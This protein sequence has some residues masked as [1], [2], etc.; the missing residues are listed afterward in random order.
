MIPADVA[1]AESPTPLNG[2]PA[3]VTFRFNTTIAAIAATTQSVHTGMRFQRSTITNDATSR[4]SSLPMSFARREAQAGPAH[5]TTQN[6]ASRFRP[7]TR[8]RPKR[9]AA[10]S[11]LPERLAT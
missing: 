9:D 7:T 10:Y 11:R 8:V 4:R 6:H 3:V 5:F 1:P 2:S